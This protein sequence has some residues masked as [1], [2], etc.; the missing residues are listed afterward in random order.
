YPDYRASGTHTAVSD[1]VYNPISQSY[2]HVNL[3]GQVIP[4]VADIFNT[5]KPSIFAGNILGGIHLLKNDEG[6]VLPPDPDLSLYPNLLPRTSPITLRS[7]RAATVE[8]V[9]MLGQ[10]IGGDYKLLPNKSVDVTPSGLL[11]GMYL[12]RFSVKGKFYTRRFIVY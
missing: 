9:T 6:H 7:D 10:K 2:G 11:P 8:F 3:G 1:I 12:A 5:D 4:V